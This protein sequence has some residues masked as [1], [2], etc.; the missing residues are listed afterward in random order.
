ME[1][2][3]TVYLN[4]LQI[5]FSQ[6][7]VPPLWI[8]SLSFKIQPFKL[9]HCF[10]LCSLVKKEV[11]KP[12]YVLFQYL[13]KLLLENILDMK[14]SHNYSLSNSHYFTSLKKCWRESCIINFTLTKLEFKSAIFKKLY[15]SK[16]SIKR[17]CE[18]ITSIQKLVW[19]N[20]KVPD[21]I[22]TTER[23]NIT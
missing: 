22:M 7:F 4:F 16:Y 3:T 6:N 11:P 19:I 8:A 5:C 23:L 13:I 10:L 14:R 15:Y 20:N 1:W 12:R 9:Q 18:Q 2:A 17:C 21:E